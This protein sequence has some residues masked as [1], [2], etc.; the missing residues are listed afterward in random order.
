ML[1]RLSDNKQLRRVLK[2]IRVSFLVSSFVALVVILVGFG[3]DRANTAAY[4][5]ELHIRTESEANLIRARVMAEINMDL[6]IV[7]DLT[8]L[9]SVSAANGEEIERQINW[10]LIQNPPFIHIAV[11]P[12]FIV[13]N[14]YPPQ[15]GNER[16]GRDVR[17][18]LFSR[19]AMTPA[20]GDQSARFYGPISID[21][22]DA[23]A[24]FFPVFVKENGQRRVWGAVE[25]VI[26]QPMFYEATGLMPARDRENRERYPHLDHLSIAIRDIGSPARA[27]TTAPFFGSSDIDGK[28]PMRQKIGFAGGKWELSVVPNSGWDAIPENRTELRLI[29]GAAGIIIIVPI[30]FATLLLGE[31]NRNITELETREAKLKELSQRLDLALESS[32]I[33][34]WELQDQDHTSSLL[35]DARAAALHGKPAQET[36][37]ALDEWLATILPEDRDIAEVHFF[38]CSIAGAACTAQ[39][40]ILLADGGIRHLR[41]VGALYKDAAGVSKTIGIVWDVTT[42]AETTDTLRKARDMSEVKNAELEL[43]LEELSSREAELAELSSRLDLALDS[44]QCGIWEARLGRGGSIWNERMH[45]LYGLAPRNGFMTEE[46]WLG[47]IHPEDRPSA[48]ESARYFKKNGDTHT[49]VCRVMASDGQVRYVRSVGKVHQTG[50]GEMKIM[51]IAF[52]AT[53]DVLMTIRLKAAK[54]EAVAKNI[55]LELAKNRIEHNSLHDPLTALANRRKLD[56][57]LENLT[58]DGRRQRQKFSILHIDLDRFK[59]IND[60]LGHAAGDAMLVH[61]SKVLARNVRGSDLV[62]RIGGDEFVI[63]ALDVGDKEMAELSTRII[64]EMRQ[65]I[66][67]QG[68]SCRC[69]VS[70]GVALANGA[71]VDARKVLINADIALY[72]AKSMGR[73]RFEFFNHNLQADIINTKRTA[74]EILSGIDNGEFTAWYQPQFSARTMELTGVEALV[75]W[76]HPSKGLL[77][78]DKFLRI[79]DEIN[80]VQMLDR[81]VLETAL[82]DKMRWTARGIAVPKVSVNVSARRLHDGSLLESLADLHIRP[83]ELSFELVESI[84]LDES[85]DVVSHNLERIKALGIDIEIDDFG[86]GHTSIV[87]LL[88]LKPKRL[89]I[90]RQLVQPIVSATQERALVSSII[91]IARSLGVETVAEG[92]ETA[93]HAELLR[94]LGCD[95]LQGYAFSRPLSF[96]DFT[97][98]ATGTRWRL[99]S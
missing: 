86:T 51:G 70:I 95:I 47:C 67:F 49:L 9:I 52:D 45:E 54:D 40:R 88:K 46:I 16:I 73:N 13:R 85:E 15:S 25:L 74:D 12:D 89:K 19:Q 58:H 75:R 7:R 81:I 72:R 4:E 68:F 60:T 33:G 92:V 35:W 96:D 84:F 82:R 63:L 34:I 57:A 39:Y 20:A 61:A 55:E 78:P 11:A 30:F 37:R 31:R 97:A 23:F 32:N 6:S 99:A 44:Y 10:L 98:E 14:V 48:L 66:D 18:A 59:E 43:A 17:E 64:E 8:N 53:E 93:A 77:T 41:S 3:L 76:K 29:V 62:A 5:R 65:P 71:H 42:D 91:E 22:R 26:D 21:G 50:T 87:S 90:D 69:G 36:S 79:A 2:N 94:D 1:S 38:S 27:A 24:I 83:G 80:V 28:D 56:I